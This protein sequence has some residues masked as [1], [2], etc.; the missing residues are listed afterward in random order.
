[1]QTA[2]RFSIVMFAA[3]C[4]LTITMAFLG[5]SSST[6]AQAHP[7]ECAEFST[8]AEAQTYFDNQGED[9][10]NL[11][12]DGNGIACDQPGDYGQTGPSAH[13]SACEDFSTQAEAQTYFDNQGEDYLNLDTDG[14]GIACDEPDASNIPESDSEATTD[15]QSL[16][17]TGSGLT[18][19]A[20]SSSA[21]ILLGMCVTVGAAAF[22]SMRRSHR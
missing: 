3:F 7:T 1:M 11:D 20:S 5:T 22:Q 2:R 4:A 12:S 16:P 9:Y 19:P 8:Q 15:V 10:L 17:V 21:A 14:N 18:L 13:P 6:V